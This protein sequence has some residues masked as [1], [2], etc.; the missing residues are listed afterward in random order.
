[1]LGWWH[2]GTLLWEFK[3]GGYRR[4]APE[5]EQAHGQLR[6]RDPADDM[7]GHWRG[8]IVALPLVQHTA[9]AEMRGLGPSAELLVRGDALDLLKALQGR[10]GLRAPAGAWQCEDSAKRNSGNGAI[11]RNLADGRLFP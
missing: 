5:Q 1:V 8:P 9:C 7:A 2:R 11:L 4:I 10:L 6:P 3:H